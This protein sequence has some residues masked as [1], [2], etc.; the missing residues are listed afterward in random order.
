[1]GDGEDVLAEGDVEPV[2]DAGRFRSRLSHDIKARICNMNSEISNC[3]FWCAESTLL[4]IGGRSHHHR[5]A[6][7][8][9][10]STTMRRARL[11]LAHSSSGSA[12][13][14]SP[15]TKTADDEAVR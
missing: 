1:M 12:A 11:A 6:V 10:M 13:A 9:D 5:C 3:P 15:S 2:T 8:R 4:E 14:T 7:H